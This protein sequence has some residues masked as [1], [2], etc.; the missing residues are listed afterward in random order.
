MNSGRRYDVVIVS[1]LR[2][3]GGT[4][5]AVAEEI[6]A[7]AAAGYRTGLVQV[8]SPLFT[9]R[10]TIN[11]R[12]RR[13]IDA[14]LAD[15]IPA[16]TAAAA[17]LLE[18]FGPQVFTHVPSQRL[19]VE[20]ETGL[21]VTTHPYLDGAGKLQYDWRQV[22]DTL[23]TFLGARPTWA[24]VG[25]L[26]RQQLAAL[27]DGPVLH[28]A[29]WVGIINPFDWAIDRAETAH[30][31]AVIGRHSRP[32]FLKWPASREEVFCAYPNHA[33]RDVRI[34]GGGA[35]LE[36]I[37]GG[38]P[39]NWRVNEFGTTAP[40]RFLKEIGIFVYFTHKDWVEAFGYAIVEAMAAGAIPVLEPQFATLF[41]DDAIIAELSEVQD[42]VDGLADDTRLQTR[43]RDTAVASVH[44]RFSQAVHQSRVRDIA[45]PPQTKAFQPK[46]VRAQETERVLFVTSN[47][48]GLGHL[49]RC[50]A[51][52]KRC[53]HPI[54]PVF[55]TMSQAF[56]FVEEA[57]FPVEYLPFHRYLGAVPAAWNAH[58][59]QELLDKLRFYGATALVFD[60]NVPYPG[61]VEAIQAL[62]QC[63]SI[64]IRRAMWRHGAKGGLLAAGQDFDAVIEPGEIAGAFDGGVTTAEQKRVL[65]TAPITLLNDGEYLPAAAARGELGLPPEATCV[66]VQVGSGN[67][68]D[69]TDVVDDAMAFLSR[70]DGVAVAYVDW[71]NRDEPA[72]LPDHVHR[73][74]TFPSARYL[75]GFDFC[76]S[77][78]GYNS[79]H[80]LCA[81]RVPTVFVPNE[82]PVMDDQLARAMFANVAGFGALA[83]RG[84][85]VGLHAALQRYLDPAERAASV[86]RLEPHMPSENGAIAAADFIWEIA[87]ASRADRPV[88]GPVIEQMR[89]AYRA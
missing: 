28:P 18:V 86:R 56:G 42:I 69:Y 5:T 11:P 54:E 88:V 74:R 61:L 7:N 37:V 20:A 50:L 8:C 47:G 83:Q 34:L 23:A 60:G 80:E 35:F 76:V 82:N 51:I 30:S 1:D 62:P 41:G 44:Q 58:L 31:R 6:A 40:M 38:Y 65:R 21:L 45:G 4:A 85:T 81:A 53:E 71:P 24:P 89:G 17:P 87:Q 64:W 27:R 73:L 55:V 22:D 68:F 12:I 43:W 79:F 33:G 75:Q 67:N 13:L 72:D 84:D 66:L 14:G 63:W 15:L 49:T 46:A 52:A 48:V 36:D 78:A 57:G 2:F 19:R 39:E 3:P 59:K 70:Q 77:S 16:D 9:W 26:V 25:P 10:R 29:D 32:H